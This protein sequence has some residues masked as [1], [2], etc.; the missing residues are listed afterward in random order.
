MTEADTRH[1][2][3]YAW[4]NER[5]ARD[6]LGGAALGERVQLGESAT[7]WE[8]AGVVTDVRHFG[9]AEE[10][11]PMI[12]FPLGPSLPGSVS[13]AAA[14]VV[15]AHTGPVGGAIELVR[16]VVSRL[17]PEVPLT[18]ALSMDEVRREATADTS[19]TVVLLGIAAAVALLLGAVGVYGVISYVVSQRTREI[20]VRMAL[21]ARAPDV[22]AMVVR[23]G[24][25][26]TLIGVGAGLAAALVLT[27]LMRAVLFE[28]SPTDPLTLV[29]VPLALLAVSSLACW[30][31]ARRAARIDPVRALALE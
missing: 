29:V 5:F 1:E 28:I 16:G 18:R 3:A 30:L 21:G 2:P 27:R 13:L 14:S 12:Y 17:G 11:E 15:V 4:V 10:V 24:M 31:P 6:F 23:Q 25:K 7:W 9:P 20:G 26:V 22:Q 8:I 19:F